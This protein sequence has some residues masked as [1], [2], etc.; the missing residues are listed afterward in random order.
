MGLWIVLAVLGMFITPQTTIATINALFADP[1][2]L[3]VTGVFTM[4]VGLIVIIIHNRW[5]GGPLAVVVTLY[6]W[7]A[8]LK[9]L[10]F[11]WLPPS[12]QAAAWKALHFDSWYYGYLAFALIIGAYLVYGGFMSDEE[13]TS[14]PTSEPARPQPP[15]PPEPPQPTTWSTVPKEEK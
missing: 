2:L 5:N 7:I 8:L 11:V 4:L 10:T 12:S 6:G 9:G 1:S 3:W 15:P 14:A 13:T